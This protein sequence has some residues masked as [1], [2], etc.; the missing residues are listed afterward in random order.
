MCRHRL[1]FFCISMTII[2][3][4]RACLLIFV[5]LSV[6]ILHTRKL[7]IKLDTVFDG[8]IDCG[9]RHVSSPTKLY[10]N[11]CDNFCSGLISRSDHF[12]PGYLYRS[13]SNGIFKFINLIT[14]GVKY[15]IF[16]VYIVVKNSCKYTFP[17]FRK[18]K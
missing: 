1:F 10:K 2:I 7:L 9:V 13:D 15:S 18:K 3:F 5:Y 4:E 11:C 14:L 17:I 12:N 16:F 6:C 8:L